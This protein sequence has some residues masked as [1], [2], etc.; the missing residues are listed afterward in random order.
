MEINGNYE[1]PFLIP[2]GIGQE[3]IDR[4]Y[5]TFESDIELYGCTRDEFKA[6]IDYASNQT[7]DT[8][9]KG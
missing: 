5:D 8:S 3:L 9:L 1:E 4:I 7:N 2:A 6:A